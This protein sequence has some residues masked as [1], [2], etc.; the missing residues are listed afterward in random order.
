VHRVC[1]LDRPSLKVAELSAFAL[2]IQGGAESGAGA[3]NEE[4]PQI[5]V[6]LLADAAQAAFAAGGT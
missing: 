1:S 5:G 4:G 6:A 3:V 2:A